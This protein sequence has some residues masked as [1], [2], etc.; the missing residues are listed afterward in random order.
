MPEHK[1]FYFL[2]HVYAKTRFYVA[3]EM[4]ESMKNENW[5]SR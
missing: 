3:S 4:I 1:L 5:Q 2:S